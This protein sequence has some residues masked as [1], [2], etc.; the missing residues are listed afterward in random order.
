M[1]QAPDYV[2]AHGSVGRV[3]GVFADGAWA[4]DYLACW[5]CDGEE[6]MRGFDPLETPLASGR[7]LLLEMPDRTRAMVAEGDARPAT[8]TLWH[9]AVALPMLPWAPAE[10]PKV[11]GRTRKCRACDGEGA[12]PRCGTPRKCNRCRG[13]GIVIDDDEGPQ[14]HLRLIEG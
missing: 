11:I 12:C 14:T 1:R 6:P 10:R 8:A 13:R 9:E 5:A 2:A 4:R 7:V 3:V